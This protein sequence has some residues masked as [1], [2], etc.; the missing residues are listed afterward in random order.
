MS[1]LCFKYQKFF[2]K[3]VDDGLQMPHLFAPNDINAFRF[4]FSDDESKNHL[5]VLVINPRRV[6][7]D[8][9]KYSGYALS[10]YD[11]E[12]K[13]V[14]RYLDLCK[15][16]KKMPLT[17]GNALSSGH[18]HNSDGM[19]S[20]IEPHTRH[21]DFYEYESCNLSQSFTIKRKLS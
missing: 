20:A 21:F 8:T 9:L 3:L 14:E 12:D 11:N 4:V 2:D 15:I 18:L 13:A 10:C 19:I 16:N 6:L 17:L 7:P 5:P 1:R